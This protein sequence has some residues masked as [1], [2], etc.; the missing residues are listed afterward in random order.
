MY[1]CQAC[2]YHLGFRCQHVDSVEAVDLPDPDTR[3]TV[4]TLSTCDL[5][6]GPIDIF[7]GIFFRMFFRIKDCKYEKVECVNH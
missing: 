7:R 3:Q 2:V 5:Y 4:G 1:A 6:L